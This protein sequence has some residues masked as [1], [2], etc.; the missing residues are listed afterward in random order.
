MARGTRYQYK[1]T[2]I[3]PHIPSGQ[4]WR[5][6]HVINTNTQKYKHSYLLASGGEG[7]T[8]SI[9]IHRNTNTHTFWPAVARGTRY[10]YKYTEIQPHI[11]SG[12]RWRGE[13]VIN[14]NSQKYNHT[15]LLASGGEGNTLSIQ[16]HRNTN[17]HTF[18]PA[19]A[20]GTRYQ[21]KYTEIQ[22]HIPSGQRW[23][24]EHVLQHQALWIGAGGGRSV[25][26]RAAVPPCRR[27]TTPGQHGIS[28]GGG[29]CMTPP[30]NQYRQFERG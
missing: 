9:Q 29:G 16:I 7:N 20:R 10:Q 6:E 2:E 25:T 14:T 26:F 23:R 30:E 4:R 24:G 27:W 13:H 5:G 3:Q 15:Y 1:Y 22:P 12:Q 8:L 18:W 21:Y 11:P 19:A 17:T 28:I